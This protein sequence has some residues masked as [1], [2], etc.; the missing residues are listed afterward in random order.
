MSKQSSYT[1]SN[2]D[3]GTRVQ[4]QKLIYSHL[5]IVNEINI[6]SLRQHITHCLILLGQSFEAH[7]LCVC[8]CALSHRPTQ[9]YQ[10]SFHIEENKISFKV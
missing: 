10:N 5:E 4:T 9:N 2:C 3:T 8:L 7:C 6:L 1:R